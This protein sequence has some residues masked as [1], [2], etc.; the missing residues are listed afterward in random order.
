MLMFG[1]DDIDRRS[2]DISF[3]GTTA[4]IFDYNQ[5]QKWA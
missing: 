3:P 2:E 4:Y 1:D 5:L